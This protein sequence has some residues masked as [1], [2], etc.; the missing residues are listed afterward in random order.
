MSQAELFPLETVLGPA[1]WEP[2]PLHPFKDP[3]L[4]DWSNGALSFLA[5]AW[6]RERRGLSWT[7][8]RDAGVAFENRRRGLYVK[9]D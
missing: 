5:C 8:L 4:Q 3:A 1:S 9:P 2:G 7:D 6:E